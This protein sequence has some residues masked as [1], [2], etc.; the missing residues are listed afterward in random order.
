MTFLENLGNQ[1]KKH[2]LSIVFV[3]T[4]T[5]WIGLSFSELDFW[6]Q[7]KWIRVLSILGSVCLFILF[8]LIGCRWMV[9]LKFDRAISESS[10][11]QFWVAIIIFLLV[12]D[13]LLAVPLLPTASSTRSA[14]SQQKISSEQ[15]TPSQLFSDMVSPITLRNAAFSKDTLTLPEKAVKSEGTDTQDTAPRVFF[16][17]LVYLLGLVVFSGILV[18]TVNRMFA[19]R[20]DRYRN[21]QTYY[22]FNDHTIV[23]GAGDTA[24]SVANALLAAQCPGFIVIMTQ[25]DVVKFR[26]RL[27]SAVDEK[28]HGR[29]IVLYGDQTSP[30]DLRHLRVNTMRQIF[31]IG[32]E[33]YRGSATRDADNITTLELMKPMR[34]TCENPVNCYVRF[35]HEATFTAFRFSDFSNRIAKMFNFIPFNLHQ[36]MAQK[37][38]VCKTLDVPHEGIKPLEGEGIHYNSDQTV[39]LVVVGM[40]QMGCT[41]AIETAR[42]CHYPNFTRNPEK[43]TR[44]TFIDPQADTKMRSLM[45]HYRELFSVSPWR[46]WESDNH[47]TDY[48]QKANME[49]VPWNTL[50]EALYDTD[51]IGRSLVDVEWEFV[52]GGVEDAT[53][54]TYLRA[55]SLNERA[56]LTVAVCWDDSHRNMDDAL[57]LPAEVYDHALQVLV[58]Q[59]G[60]ESAVKMLTDT[61][62]R[63]NWS[64]RYKKLY[65]FG[66]VK[67]GMD[68]S[69][70][71]YPL[72][73]AVNY[74][75]SSMT[76]DEDGSVK[77]ADYL[78]DGVKRDRSVL[79]R[80]W[81][82]EAQNGKTQ[83][84]NRWS[85]IC[86]AQSV[87]IKLRN[88]GWKEGNPLSDEEEEIL[89]VVEHYRWNMEQLIAGYRP[90]QRGDSAEYAVKQNGIHHCI[91]GYDL[92]SSDFKKIDRF[93]IK[94]L[95]SL[96]E[97]WKNSINSDTKN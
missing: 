5:V 23:I 24:I 51:S 63:K 50:S 14:Q 97:F 19:T 37:I 16:P 35:D 31:I 20:A 93:F 76:W 57:Y 34:Q 4:S 46:Y 49:S 41:M 86:A 60:N 43:R 45:N 73:L 44:I 69:Q 66:L 3:L 80:E 58:Y 67:E 39:H 83:A 72:A 8:E 79:L 74:I 48:Y 11:S 40:T 64:P 61:E 53:V 27:L 1:I 17:V 78:L 47:D 42:L 33:P 75:Y 94:A 29:L 87:W 36:M 88:I 68:L 6:W 22:R 90:V 10:L 59:S 7:Y 38:L 84:S 95:P 96:Y 82:K 21:G 55:R 30:D 26:K 2:W 65:S 28:F 71:E 54:Q 32:D 15:Y 12:F 13:V 9:R 70:Y 85:N 81:V 92:L 56:V 52:K 89:A 25:D 91:K 62:I 77:D 18:A